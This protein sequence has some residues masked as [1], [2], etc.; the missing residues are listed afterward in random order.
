MR[1]FALSDADKAFFRKQGYFGP[2]K[3]YSPE[4]ARDRYRR[5]GTDPGTGRSSRGAGRWNGAMI[6]I[7]ASHDREG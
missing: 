1:E 2:F 7:T 4:E 6:D 3:I 5:A